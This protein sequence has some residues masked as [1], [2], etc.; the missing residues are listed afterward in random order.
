MNKFTDKVLAA[1][2]E[3]QTDIDDYDTECETCKKPSL[4]HEGPCTRSE[5]V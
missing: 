2:V 1:K 5:T 4:L 3:K